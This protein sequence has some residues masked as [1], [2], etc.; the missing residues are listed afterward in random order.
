MSLIFV[1]LPDYNVEEPQE[2]KEKVLPQGKKA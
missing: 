1:P 2:K